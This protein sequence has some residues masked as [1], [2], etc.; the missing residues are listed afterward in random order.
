MKFA[1]D[2][3]AHLDSPFHRW[4][5]RFN[6]LALT[7]HYLFED[8]RKTYVDELSKDLVSAFRGLSEAGSLELITCSATHGYLPLMSIMT[9]SGPVEELTSS[10]SRA[11]GERKH[12]PRNPGRRCS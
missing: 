1:L 11:P 10:R 3:Y 7:Y 5:P 2:E 12:P 4:D 6:R 8:T 9:L